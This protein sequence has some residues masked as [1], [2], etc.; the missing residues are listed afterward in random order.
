MHAYVDQLGLSTSPSQP[1]HFDDAVAYL[2]RCTFRLSLL[3]SCLVAVAEQTWPPRTNASHVLFHSNKVH[4][5][6]RCCFPSWRLRIIWSIR[7][8][9]R[10]LWLR[11]RLE[12]VHL[13]LTRNGTRRFNSLPGIP[14]WTFWLIIEAAEFSMATALQKLPHHSESHWCSETCHVTSLPHANLLPFSTT[15]PFLYRGGATGAFGS[16]PKSKGPFSSALA[17]MP[18]AKCKGLEVKRSFRNAS[19]VW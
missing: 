12:R 6:F 5:L 16:I 15:I 2:T 14:D 19:S 13:L 11:D 4:V 18:L 3:S 7:N 1:L 17:G 10:R 9:Q 8:S